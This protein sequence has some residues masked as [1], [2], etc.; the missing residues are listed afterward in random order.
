MS[1]HEWNLV[2]ANTSVSK[3]VMY[4]CNNVV[5]M[6]NLVCNHCSV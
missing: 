1:G 5:I 2:Y 3:C 6:G 4:M